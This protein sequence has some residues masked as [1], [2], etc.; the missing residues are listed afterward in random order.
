MSSSLGTLG[1][2][3][4]LQHDVALAVAYYHVGN[5]LHAEVHAEVAIGVEQFLV[6]PSRDY[7]REV[8]PYLIVLSLVDGMA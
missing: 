5:S 6:L 3:V 7:R 4:V 8:S 2:A 1:I